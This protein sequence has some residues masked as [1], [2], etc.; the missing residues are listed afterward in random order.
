VAGLLRRRLTGAALSRGVFGE[1]R[2][3]LVIAIMMGVRF[4]VR[5]LGGDGPKVLFS[6]ELGPNDRLLIGT[7]RDGE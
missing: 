1:S 6:E 5:R 2:F 4:V 3:W 7:V